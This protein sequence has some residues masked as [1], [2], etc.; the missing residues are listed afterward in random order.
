MKH[1]ISKSKENGDYWNAWSGIPL[2]LKKKRLLVLA[3]CPVR[4]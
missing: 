4:R 1:T 2:Y 3:G